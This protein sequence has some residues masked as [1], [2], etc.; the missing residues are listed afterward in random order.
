M[1]IHTISLLAAKHCLWTRISLRGLPKNLSQSPQVFMSFCFTTPPIATR[2]KM[3]GSSFNMGIFN[4]LKKVPKGSADPQKCPH[5]RWLR[6]V[7]VLKVEKK[8]MAWSCQASA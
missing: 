7:L 2:Y 3:M 5:L 8:N 1:T 4:D 6:S